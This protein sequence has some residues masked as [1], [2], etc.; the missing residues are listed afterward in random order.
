MAMRFDSKI[1]I[2]FFVFLFIGCQ[3]NPQLK[4]AERLM[5]TDVDSAYLLIQKIKPGTLHTSA[6]KALYALLYCQVLDKKEIYT[7]TDSIISIA[8][9]YYENRQHEKAAYSWFYKSRIAGHHSDAEGKAKFL[10]KAQQHAS[11]TKNDKL[12]G[13]IYS[14]KASMYYE[15]MIFD[16]SV[17]YYQKA[18]DCFLRVKDTV[19]YVLSL[20]GKAYMYL[21]A[22][23]PDSAEIILTAIKPKLPEDIII[24]SYYY[25]V[26]GLVLNNKC[27]YLQS[28][29]S[30]KK[31]SQTGNERYDDNAKYLIAKAYL[32]A[33]MGDSALHYF[34]LMHYIGE[35]APDYYQLLK[36]IYKDKGDY[37]MALQYEEKGFSAV[38][39]IYKIKLKESFTGM[40]RKFNYQRLQIDNNKLK[41]SNYNKGY[42]LMIC[43]LVIAAGFIL[44]LLNR[45]N[46]RRRQYEFELLLSETE[47]SRLKKEQENIRLS[48]IQSSLQSII[49]SNL[50][51]YRKNAYKSPQEIKKGFHPVN[52]ERFKAEV[53]ATIDHIYNH[54]SERL[55]EE[56]PS[57]NDTDI[58]ICC[59]LLAGYETG[60]IATVLQIK[61]DSMNIR[62]S[63]L[64]K[65]LHLSN[66]ENLID[67]LRN[68]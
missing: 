34:R 22:Q 24:N 54:L 26:L 61:P 36:E 12:Q 68:F 56:F 2:P 33:G 52:N 5:D 17:V 46:S 14:D 64:R 29:Q 58:F 25:K 67:F 55:V 7:A 32:R 47:R 11:N 28:I 13:L 48:E 37:R 19:N 10:L 16:S 3:S 20:T 57:L 23:Q 42:F 41:I 31:I 27:Q 62:R 15:E 18:S 60:V 21:N 65:K 38:D 1:F 63:R 51:Q 66:N 59:L 49:F 50:E 35:M 40:E 4:V 53:L 8:A 44:F 30:Y 39:S 6:D 45:S 9:D 43:L